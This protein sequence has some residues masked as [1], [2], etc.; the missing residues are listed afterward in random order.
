MIF[1]LFTWFIRI[2]TVGGIAC[3]ASHEE[4]SYGDNNQKQQG[5]GDKWRGFHGMTQFI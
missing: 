3:S 5:K 1:L 4:C 2:I